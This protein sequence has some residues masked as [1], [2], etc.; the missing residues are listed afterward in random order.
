MAVVTWYPGQT[1]DS[2]EKDIIEESIKIYP[3]IEAAAKSL[4]VPIRTMHRRIQEL[5][6]ENARQER[7]MDA[8]IASQNEAILRFKRMASKTTVQQE[9]NDYRRLISKQ[10]NTA[11]E[12]NETAKKT[13][14]KVS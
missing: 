9:R 12:K 13:K 5:K 2:V 8:L 11:A 14:Q 1:L 10:Q 6:E 7:S 4:G 3:T